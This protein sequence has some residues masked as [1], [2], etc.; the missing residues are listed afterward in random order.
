MGRLG[1]AIKA[2]SNGDFLLSQ[3][4]AIIEWLDETHPAIKLLP[5]EPIARA[6]VR[7]LAYQ[8]AMEM[9]P[10]NNL[11]VLDYLKNDLGIEET[12]KMTW[13]HHWITV[14]FDALEQAL[15]QS[16]SN[17]QFCF[18]G[19]VTLADVCLIPQVY[20]ARRFECDLEDYPLIGSISEHCSSL[21]AFKQAAP[22]SQADYR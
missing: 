1:A 11:R 12:E 14:G 13:Y 6:Q 21:R 4:L 18:G 16:D 7:A 5:M 3:S 15:H 10:M 19:S 17:G 22:E 9:H 2:I 8:V 20:N